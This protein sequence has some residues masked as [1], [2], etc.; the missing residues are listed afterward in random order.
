MVAEIL[1]KFNMENGIK[2]NFMHIS[3]KEAH[4]FVKYNEKERIDPRAV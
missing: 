2:M 3:Q 1:T 4:I